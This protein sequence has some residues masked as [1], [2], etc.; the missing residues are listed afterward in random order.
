MNINPEQTLRRSPLYRQHIEAGATFA[1]RDNSA[2][3]SYF[4]NP[5]QEQEQAVSL[6]IIDL[7][8]LARTGFK[9]ADTVSLLTANAFSIPDFPNQA[10]INDKGLIVAR[11]SQQEVFILDS[12]SESSGEIERLEN[13]WGEDLSSNSFQLQRADSHAWFALTGKSA[14]EVLAKVCAVDMRL[15]KFENLE[16][17]QTS[18]ARSNAIVVRV[19]QT[20]FPCFYILSDLSGSEFLWGCMLDAMEEFEGKAV[21]MDVLTD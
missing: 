7:S 2:V 18:V 20:S 12:V 10:L 19:D 9:G 16:V 6:A 8:P 17:A 1:E 3:V 11:L 14:P 15:N 4:S 21:G 5:Q 13:L